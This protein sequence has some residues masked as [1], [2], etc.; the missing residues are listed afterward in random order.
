YMYSVSNDLKWRNLI[1]AWVSFESQTPT[2]QK[3]TTEKRPDQ[4]KV[5][6]KRAKSPMYLPEVDGKIFGVQMES[7]WK[8]IQ[9]EW[10]K[11]NSNNILCRSTPEDFSWIEM[12]FGGSTGLCMV[13][14]ALSWWL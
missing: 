3:L 11:S 7:W 12:E 9:P 1:S 5:W 4:L 10:R 6:I 14:M 8:A 2:S 13:V